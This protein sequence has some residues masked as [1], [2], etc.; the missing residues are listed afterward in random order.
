MRKTLSSIFATLA[1]VLFFTGCDSSD[2]EVTYP[3]DVSIQNYKLPNGTE[4]KP[5][6]T[7]SAYIINS[8]TY[9]SQL[10]LPATSSPAIDLTKYSLFVVSPRHCNADSRL[11]QLT[12]IKTADRKYILSVNVTPSVTANA[13]PLIIAVTVPEKEKEINVDLKIKLTTE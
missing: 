4:W 9:F 10:V 6:T 3:T 2:K 8:T 12:L 1:C 5:L 7:D 11:N 13:A